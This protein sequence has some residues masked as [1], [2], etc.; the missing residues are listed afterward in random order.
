MVTPTRLKRPNAIRLTRA[1]DR[2]SFLYMDKAAIH[3]DDNG[4][5]ATVNMNTDRTEAKV[6]LPAASLSVLLLGPGTSIT[7]QATAALSQAGCGVSFVGSGTVRSYGA[8]MSPYAPTDRL[9]RQA[10]IVSDPALRVEAA[11]RMYEKRFPSSLTKH[12]DASEASIATLRGMEGIRMRGLYEGL[13]R[14]HRM[15]KWRRSNGRD[16]TTLD[17]VN[18]AI[19]HANTALYGMTTAVITAM[20]MSPG[21]GV[22]HQGNR[23]AFALDIADLF[24]ADTT[25]PAAFSVK[26]SKDPGADVLRMLRINFGLIRIIPRMLNDIDDILGMTPE[27]DPNSDYDPDDWLVDEIRLWGETGTVEGGFNQA[28]LGFS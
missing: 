14:K 12:L 5:L 24:K 26:D 20:G 10:A 22:V 17:P 6:Y 7:Q 16:G 27:D 15:T 21:L 19:N 3:Q 13:A 18:E 9:M 8:F 23:L 28:G 11:K 2:L 25:I 4:T 1:S